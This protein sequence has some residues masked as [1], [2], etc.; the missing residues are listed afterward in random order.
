V[1]AF[2]SPNVFGI[3]TFG[4]KNTTLYSWSDF[5]LRYLRSKSEIDMFAFPLFEHEDCFHASTCGVSIGT[6]N[7]VPSGGEFVVML[8]EVAANDKLYIWATVP[9]PST[10]AMMLLG[11][12]G[13]SLVRSR[14]WWRSMPAVA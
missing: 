13:L 8:R 14:R 9:E 6:L 2:S 4:V 10:W 1:T 5:H 11:I 3:V 12:A 7:G